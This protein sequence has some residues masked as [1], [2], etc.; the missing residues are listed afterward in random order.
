MWRRPERASEILTDLIILKF[1]QF[2]NRF[3]NSDIWPNFF[4]LI[5]CILVIGINGN[6]S[7]IGRWIKFAAENNEKGG[8]GRMVTK[9]LEY[10][11]PKP[12]VSP[13]LVKFSRCRRERKVFFWQHGDRIPGIGPP[14]VLAVQPSVPQSKKLNSPFKR[15][16]SRVLRHPTTLFAFLPSQNSDHSGLP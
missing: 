13:K 4:S 9:F 1:G 3:G 16:V 12:N 14:S 5:N 15:S 7:I 8:F 6:L 2:F 11:A 10:Q